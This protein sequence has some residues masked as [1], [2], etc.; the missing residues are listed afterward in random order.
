MSILLRIAALYS[1]GWAVALANPSWL[2]GDGQLLSPEGRSLARGLAIANAALAVL[3]W[4]AARDPAAERWIIYAALFFF[5]ARAVVGTCEVLY[6]L[7]GVAATI[8]L[9]DFVLSLA[10]FVGLLNAL[11]GVLQGS[12]KAESAG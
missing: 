8:R 10:C 3:F 5:G 11:P 7:D 6:S 2:P 12:E 9:I 4:R 1:L